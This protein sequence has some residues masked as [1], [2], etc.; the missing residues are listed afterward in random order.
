MAERLTDSEFDTLLSLMHRFCETDLDQ[1]DHW[2]LPGTY[3]PYYIAITIMPVY[4]TERAYREL[5]VK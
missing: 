4:G 1:H 3:G 2:K 5:P